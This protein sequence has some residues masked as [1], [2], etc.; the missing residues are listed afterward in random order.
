MILLEVVAALDRFDEDQTVYVR[1]PWL[2]NSLATVQLEPEAGGLPDA[3]A[4]HGMQYFLEV[5]VAR[6]VIE[7]WSKTQEA[8]PKLEAKTERLIQYAIND[9]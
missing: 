1:E 9:A 2:P 6:E 3:A 8:E 4:E 5:S 7:D